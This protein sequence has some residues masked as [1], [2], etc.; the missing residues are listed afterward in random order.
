LIIQCAVSLL[1]VGIVIHIYPWAKIWQNILTMDYLW[2]AF[3]LVCFIPTLLVVSWRWRMLLG[4]QGVQL[5]FWR[6]FEL[7]MIGQFFSTVGVGATGGDVFKIFYVARAVP[8]RRTAVAFTVIVDRVIGLIALV[9][10]GAV[11]AS[12]R[13][14][15]LTS[16][17]NTKAA[18]AVF[19]LFVV[20][21]A[22]CAVLASVGPYFLNRPFF[23][24]LGQKLPL[25]HRGA[26]LYAAYD[27]SARAL[28]TNVLAVIASVPSH[29]SITAMAYC[30]MLAMPKTAEFQMPDTVAFCA[31]VAIVNLLIAMPVSVSG[32]GLRELL[33]PMFLALVK[34]PADKAGTFAI[35]YFAMSTIWNLAGG[36]FYFMYRHETHTPPPD[37]DEVQP[38]FDQ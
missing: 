17:P 13:V 15:L 29:M 28:G 24:K 27:C 6:V 36:P 21:A 12:F 32:L 22:A 11:L 18:M 4:V 5:R 2:L 34:V 37:T 20:G 9:L 31:I 23:K 25:A 14:T 16:T 38:I 33:F 19:G 30:I 35:T 26:K 1:A 8:D 3:G 10:F 7:T